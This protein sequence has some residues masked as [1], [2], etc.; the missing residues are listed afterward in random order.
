M[1]GI[2]RATVKR[3][4]STAKAAPAFEPINGSAAPPEHARPDHAV[5][6]RPN[7]KAG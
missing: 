6:C 1:L 7:A 4:W 3:E 5:I 2:S